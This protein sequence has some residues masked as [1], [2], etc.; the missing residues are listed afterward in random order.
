MTPHHP[1]HHRG[2]RHCVVPASETEHGSGCDGPGSLA[3]PCPAKEPT[4]CRCSWTNLLLQEPKPPF[5]TLSFSPFLCLSP[6]PVCP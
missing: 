1:H 3:T 6:P 2:A 4:N 5:F